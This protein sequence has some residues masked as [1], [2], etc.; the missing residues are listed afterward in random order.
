ML[1][2]QGPVWEIRNANFRRAF[3]GEAAVFTLLVAFNVATGFRLGELGI[4]VLVFVGGPA[5]YHLVSWRR[6]TLEVGV[7]GIVLSDLWVRRRLDWP[8]IESFG[9]RAP[10]RRSLLM[11]LA[12]PCADQA[13][14]LLRDGSR[15]RIRAVQPY[16]GGAAPSLFQVRG[17]TDSDRLVD[18]LNQLITELRTPARNAA[19]E[20]TAVR[21]TG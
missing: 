18:R 12:A 15:A 14:V 20:S 10:G 16:H 3:L 7:D 19:L 8:E 6:A 5:I 13:R 21:A 9:I 17:M 2:L 4:G 1:H 11:L